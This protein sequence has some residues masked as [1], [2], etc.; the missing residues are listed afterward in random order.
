MNK[1]LDQHPNYTAALRARGRIFLARSEIAAAGSAFEDLTRRSPD[2]AEHWY[3]RGTAEE[4][5]ALANEAYDSYT[6]AIQRNA[7][8]LYVQ[9]RGKLVCVYWSRIQKGLTRE[10]LL[11]QALRDMDDAVRRRRTAEALIERADCKLQI[12][13]VRYPGGKDAPNSVW[14]DTLAGYEAGFRLLSQGRSSRYDYAI[15]LRAQ[16][17]ERLGN[18]EQAILLY[19][20]VVGLEKEGATPDIVRDARA[21]LQRLKPEAA[22]A[23]TQPTSTFVP[24]AIGPAP[25]VPVSLSIKEPDPVGLLTRAAQSQANNNIESA[26]ADVD[27]V[28]AERPK[29]APALA[30]K[31]KLYF[32]RQVYSLAISFLSAALEIDARQSEW[33]FLL[34]FAQERQLQFEPA[35]RSYN[36]AIELTPNPAFVQARLALLCNIPSLPQT[37]RGRTACPP[38]VTKK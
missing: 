19:E 16:L 26:L 15:A 27:R 5:R 37:A 33:W 14:T 9:A 29:Y 10:E 23:A 1:I 3:L 30:A 4:A 22:P 31:G 35:L 28:L 17:N 6:N 25:Q 21:A 12:A 20:V 36:R 2:I 32:G 18:P 11:Q 8:A 38:R 7:W 13:E 24:L 34:G